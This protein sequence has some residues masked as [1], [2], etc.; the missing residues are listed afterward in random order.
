MF[1]SLCVPFG[2][3]SVVL[4]INS[5]SDTGLIAANF[6]FLICLSLINLLFVY[7]VYFHMF[8]FYIKSGENAPLV[9]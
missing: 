2:H 4:K 6:N 3:L 9:I 1:A 8:I 7:H 5:T